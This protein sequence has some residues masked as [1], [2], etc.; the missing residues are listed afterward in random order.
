MRKPHRSMPMSAW[1]LLLGSLLLAGCAQSARGPELVLAT[2]NLEHLA[3]EDGAGCRPRSA[4]DYAELRA[5]A[6][7]L[8]A[9]VIALQ[10]VESARAVA[11]VFDPARFDIH[12]SNR[13]VTMRDACRGRPGQRRT[14]LDTGFAIDRE[15]LAALGLR[16][17]ALPPLRQLG[18]DGQRWG[19]RIAL[20]AMADDGEGAGLELL[21]VHLKSGCGWGDL[22]L[23]DRA[24]P[25]RRGQCRTL[26]R[27][28]GILEQWID[29]RAAVGTPF[30]ILGD[31]NRQ[32]DQPGDEFWAAIDDGAVCTWRADRDLGR[33]CLPG[34]VMADP[35]A[36]LRL[37]N[38]GR[39]F[40]YPYNSR[41]PYAIDHLVFGG[42]A[43]DWAIDR[44]YRV[45]GYDTEP[46][47]SD[48]HPIRMTLRLPWGHP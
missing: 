47:P 26:R 34:T 42:A 37:A 14:A 9:D 10:E 13:P 6:Q 1:I 40:P 22:G 29:G 32:L 2:W 48:H 7:R 23:D 18:E 36:D 44:S 25:I 46:A 11:R 33:R 4:A 38:A 12:L 19:A 20:D 15:R 35:N 21:T 24:H 41:Y 28:R 30:V 16:W 31:F 39:P 17:R 27:Q 43:A 3:A 5:V 8:A 45:L